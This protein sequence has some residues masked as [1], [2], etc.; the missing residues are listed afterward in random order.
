MT[1]LLFSWMTSQTVS[2]AN[3]VGLVRVFFLGILGFR[4]VNISQVKTHDIQ[5]ICCNN[6]GRNSG[7]LGVH[8]FKHIGSIMIYR[9]NKKN[10]R[11]WIREFLGFDGGK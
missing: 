4:G 9:E 2:L 5:K 6:K 8:N 7:G 11:G 3:L 1:F 10:T